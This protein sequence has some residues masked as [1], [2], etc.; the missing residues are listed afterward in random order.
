MMKL[1]KVSWLAFIVW[2]TCALTFALASCGPTPP[3]AKGPDVKVVFP[4]NGARGY[5]GQT[6]NVQ[7]VA[8]DNQGVVKIELWMD[9]QIYRV[10]DAPTPEGLPV[11]TAA[12]AWT[13]DVAGTHSLTAKAYTR[14]GRNAQSAPVLIFVQELPTATPTLTL[15]ATPTPLPP[16][17]TPTPTFIPLPTPTSVPS[18]TPVPTPT[19]SPP[20]SSPGQPG[21]P[22]IPGQPGYPSDQPGYP[23]YPPS[24][25]GYPA[26]PPG[27][28]GY[29][30]YPPGQPGYPVNPGYP[31]IPGYPPNQPS[32]PYPPSQPVYPPGVPSV[33]QAPV[34][35]ILYP[36]QGTHVNLGQ[37]V[38]VRSWA[39]DD[40][41]LARVELSVDGAV[42]QAYDAR[43][44]QAVEVVQV[45]RPASPGGHTLE[46]KAYD[47][48]MQPSIPARVTVY[49]D[50]VVPNPPPDT[51]I[52][53]VN[54]VSPVSGQQIPAGQNVD[55]VTIASDSAGLV[56]LELWV[57][58][59][60]FTS[61]SLS[62][63]RQTWQWVKPWATTIPG[64][65]IL[66]ARARDVMGNV[67]SSAPLTLIV[68][69]AP[70]SA[71]RLYFTSQQ[72]GSQDIYSIRPDGSDLR[73]LTTSNRPETSP[74]VSRDGQMLSFDL[75]GAIWVMPAS[76]GS[77]TNLISNPNPADA[78]SHSAW[79]P[80]RQRLAYVQNNQIW[81]YN[82]AG[83]SRRQ[84]TSGAYSYELPSY[85]SDGTRLACQSWQSG[86]NSSI[87]VL[88]ES[89]GS[90][91]NAFTAHAGSD[92]APV[93][94]PDGTRIAFV[95]TGGVD[96]GIYVMRSD[97][98]NVVRITSQGWGPAWSP[99]GNQLG[100]VVPAGSQAELW[101]VNADGSNAQRVLGGVSLDRV[102]WGS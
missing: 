71:G 91:V 79:S 62:Q 92:G 87:Y 41:G 22:G 32:Y 44:Q 12:Q 68:Q 98:T 35:T 88:N 73:Q 3:P 11:F 96:A 14:D 56:A 16:T 63:P 23:A 33:P 83:G 67:G 95:R 49:V 15:T 77:P 53:T 30:A 36:V 20:V 93:Y 97:G 84:V 102:A 65:H 39:R 82:Y 6:I 75:D 26:Y 21:Y 78:V 28:P 43:G 55:I 99:N 48:N 60:L 1:R 89:N 38:Q 34:V 61:E 18:D 100:Y 40:M 52:P 19:V 17:A 27:Q 51:S 76:G 5:Q 31:G 70:T 69:G 50:Q 101:T 25:P 72:A 29:P 13:T 74:A 94:S 86:P 42:Y 58:G 46:V 24:Q 81:V 85:S 4:E 59:T 64:Q 7:S 57:D 66:V 90:V 45:W 47:I 2:G 54:I 9:G 37:D 8:V 80:D 10:D